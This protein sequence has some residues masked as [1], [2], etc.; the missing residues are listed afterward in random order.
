MNVLVIDCNR[1]GAGPPM[2]PATRLPTLTNPKWRAVKLFADAAEADLTWRSSKTTETPVLTGYDVLVF[3]RAL[4]SPKDNAI[5]LDANPTARVFH[6]TNDYRVGGGSLYLA[7]RALGR[8]VETI[9]NYPH[10]MSRVAGQLTAKWHVANLN[11]LLYEPERQQNGHAPGKGCVYYGAARPDRQTIFQKYLTGQVTVAQYPPVW[12]EFE[13]F[14]CTGPWA[15]RVDWGTDGLYP[16]AAAIYLENPDQ[17]A[18]GGTPFFANRFYETLS[19][20]R[21]PIFAAECRQTI[22]QSGY[23]IPE[24]AIVDDP[25]QIP[26]AVAAAD[27]AQIAAWRA[28]AAEEQ[29]AVLAQMR[30]II[31]G[32]E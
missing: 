28:E 5:W 17:T 13:A 25:A 27:T 1:M 29:L 23:Q 26:E 31:R 22:R 4:P 2:D 10:A 11:T 19:Y 12:T 24:T 7:A 3:S 21:W 30:S 20:D 32:T 14:G 9:A 8:P 16:W 6:L 15:A 18:L